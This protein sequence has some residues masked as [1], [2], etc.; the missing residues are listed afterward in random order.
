MN[1]LVFWNELAERP[2]ASDRCAAKQRMDG[3]IDAFAALR[4]KLTRTP[5]RLRT[6]EP[7]HGVMLA[8]NYSVAN[9]QVD[10]DQVRRLLFL[11]LAA[12]SPVLR[13]PE[14]AAEVLERYGCAECWYGAERGVGLRAAWASDQ[15]S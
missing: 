4:R 9:W 15:L 10:T 14:D 1:P 13:K 8:P 12:S 7:I 5:P 3:F 2:Q 11:Q 6:H